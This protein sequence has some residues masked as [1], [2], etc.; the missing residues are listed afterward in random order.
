MAVLN[1][2]DFYSTLNEALS[3]RTSPQIEFYEYK[4]VQLLPNNILPYSQTTNKVDGIEL[5]DWSVFV[6]DL[7]TNEESEIT[8]NFLVENI[9]EDD[10][11][12]A[13]FDWSVTNIPFDF[14]YN[15]VYLRA[16]QSIGETFYSNPFQLTNK[17]YEKTTRIDYKQKEDDTM[18]SIQLK[19]WFWQPLKNQ[20]LTTYYETSTKN[21]VSVLIKSQNYERWLTDAVSND[22]L[23]KISEV[24]EKKYCYVDLSR[25]NLFEAIEPKEHSNQQNFESNEIKIA[26]NRSDVY[27]PLYEEPV[28]INN[29]SIVL[30]NVIPNGVD[31][32]YSFAF[33]DFTPTFLTFQ[34]S[35]DQVN[36]NSTNKG[37]TSTQS[38][39]FNGTGT[40]YFRII[41][42][43]AISNVIQL[44]LGSTVVANND[45]INIIKGGIVEISVLNNDVLVGSTTIT[46][47]TSPTN[48]IAEIIESGTKIR[49]TH[50]DSATIFDTF[51]Y[52]ISNGI[53]NDSA[54]VSVQISS[55]TENSNS[56]LMNSSG[57]ESNIASCTQPLEV[58]RYFAGR[59]FI[60]ETGDII[61]SDESLSTVFVGGDKWYAVLFEYPVSDD[62][63]EIDAPDSIR[64]NDLGEITQKH[65]C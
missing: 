33:S 44:D 51:D 31:A 41:H 48:G 58:T 39:S 3:I 55:I 12:Q 18:Q 46:S 7:C 21:T 49:Y 57:S 59:A 60:P 38:L 42:P 32:V 65:N 62:S 23:I 5:E 6:V 36:W 52:T 15:L 20:E 19:M 61:Y 10:N 64:I 1:F 14:G 47:V 29:P 34:T 27:D 54:S 17:D 26:F 22:L 45:N 37:V 28:I 13:Q 4:G 11:G 53:T 16:E 63:E 24:F 8:D 35:Q 25:C 9:F 56:F 2:I 30:A 40:W 43:E 50:N